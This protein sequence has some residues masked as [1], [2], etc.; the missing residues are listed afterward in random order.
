MTDSSNQVNQ[1]APV[2]APVDSLEYL[3]YLGGRKFTAAMLI[4]V[5]ATL[6]LPFKLI[7]GDIWK[8]VTITVAGLYFG[9]NILQKI[10]SKSP[11]E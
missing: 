4:L 3:K 6:L 11:L 2:V 9:A 1:E 7:T 10:F 8:D 5:I